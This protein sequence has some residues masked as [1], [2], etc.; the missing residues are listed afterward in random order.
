MKKILMKKIMIKK[1]KKILMTTKKI[2][3]NFFVYIKMVNKYKKTRKGLK[4]Q[5]SER[6][7]NL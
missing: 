1:N 4:K 6:Y 3:I 2:F 7:Q 5:T